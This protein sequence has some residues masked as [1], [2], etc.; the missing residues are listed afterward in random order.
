[1]SELPDGWPLRPARLH[2]LPPA[3]LVNY[4]TDRY[5]GGTWVVS[6]AAFAPADQRLLRALYQMLTELWHQLTA[7]PQRDWP[8]LPAVRAALGQSGWYAVLEALPQ[9]GVATAAQS[10]PDPLAGV[11]DAVRA[12]N[13]AVL[14]GTL[15]LLGLGP[16][17]LDTVV[18][19][20]GLVRDHLH[21]LRSL[22]PDLDPHAAA[23]DQAAQ[24][25]TLAQLVEKWQHPPYGVGHTV[26]DVR[27]AIHGTGVVAAQGREWAAVDSV[28]TT[29]IA[30]AVAQ[31]GDGIVYVV[32]L[33][34]GEGQDVRLVVYHRSATRADVP[35]DAGY[36]W[37]RCA[38]YVADCYGVPTV[39][40]CLDAQYL[41]ADVIDVYRVAWFHWPLV[42]AA[43]AP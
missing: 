21:M 20:V 26:A 13:V 36:G 27:V 28:L 1:M 30:A 38:A 40:Q 43:A 42:P 8:V 5:A 41:A 39:Q 33:A 12:G 15:P 31:A 29:L 37:A 22:L 10:H 14:H 17:T 32:L 19:L 7:V 18:P 4:R 24:P 34:H 16:V 25:H 2:A 35:A 23:T 6:L 11:L 3:S 9:L